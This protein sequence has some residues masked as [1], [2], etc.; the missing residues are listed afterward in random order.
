MWKELKVSK[1]ISVWKKMLR[2]W[3]LKS[4][5]KVTTIKL[6]SLGSQGKVIAFC[7]FKMKKW[8][9]LNSKAL[10]LPKKILRLDTS[11]LSTLITWFRIHKLSVMDNV[12][13]NCC[14][15]SKT[16]VTPLVSVG[17]ISFT[18]SDIHMNYWFSPEYILLYWPLYIYIKK[19]YCYIIY[20]HLKTY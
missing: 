15:G 11:V 9:P 10:L 2:H 1:Q 3:V 5:Q 17:Q 16:L 19:K 12:I 6:S 20:S 8:V 13:W 14:M 18:S 4:L 7:N